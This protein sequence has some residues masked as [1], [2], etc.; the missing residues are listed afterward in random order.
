MLSSSAVMSS[1]L[2]SVPE[3]DGGS[4]VCG[5]VSLTAGD[6]GGCGDKGG[7]DRGVAE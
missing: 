2:L 1:G 7:E 3:G 6:C 4:A 5:I